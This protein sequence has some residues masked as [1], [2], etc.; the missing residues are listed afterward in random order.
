MVLVRRNLLD[1]ERAADALPMKFAAASI[2]LL[3]LIVLASTA[4]S[5][6][7]EEKSIHDCETAILEIDSNAKLMSANGAGSKITLDINIP[8]KT[9]LV[10]GAVPDQEALW[11]VDANNYF[12]HTNSRDIIGQ[13]LA[14]YSNKNLTGPISL[15]PGPHLLTLESVKSSTNNR[16]FV[17]VYEI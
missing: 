13:S 10:L 4:V 2:V 5:S 11:P 3:I 12:I 17:K 6:L 9:L 16:I 8:K 14:S 1:D 7:L 15:G